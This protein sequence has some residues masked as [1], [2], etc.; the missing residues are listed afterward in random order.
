MHILTFIS[1]SLFI[2]FTINGYL[3]IGI[4]ST[5]VGVTARIAVLLGSLG[6]DI[7]DLLQFTAQARIL[8][9]AIYSFILLLEIFQLFISFEFRI[10]YCL[11]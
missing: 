1:L 9:N 10:F 4:Q 11:T 7:S 5:A 2:S 8:G 6:L 3:G